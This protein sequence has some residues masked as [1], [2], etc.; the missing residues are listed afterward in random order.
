MTTLLEKAGASFLRAFG[1]SMIVLL[2]GIWLAPNLKVGLALA[3]AAVISSLSAALKVLQTFFPSLS[4]ASLVGQPYG[5]WLDSFIRAFLAT[6]VTAVTTLLDQINVAN[7]IDFNTLKA[8]GLAA[9]VGA[10]AAGFRAVQ[11]VTTKGEVP[12]PDKGLAPPA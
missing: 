2:P 11:G 5:A 4:F 10:I 9:L 8:A 12:A 3:I 6:F 1:A 7:P